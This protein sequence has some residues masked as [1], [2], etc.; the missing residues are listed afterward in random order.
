[1]GYHEAIRY[2]SGH[3]DTVDMVK[4]VFYL[5]IEKVGE[6]ASVNVNQ[7]TK[8]TSLSNITSYV[9]GEI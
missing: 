6:K 1:M 2:L 4:S 7:K 3:E 9:A 5:L 8:R